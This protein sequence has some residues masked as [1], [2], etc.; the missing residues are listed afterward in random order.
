MI[1]IK[2]GS[3]ENWDT[4]NPILEAGQPGYDKNTHKLKIGDGITKWSEL[5]AIGESPT[6]RSLDASIKDFVV[7]S[8]VTDIW[9]YQ[10]WYSGIARCSC[11]LPVNT[12]ITT[13]TTASSI[14]QAD[15]IIAGINYPINFET[16]PS[17]LATLQSNVGFAWLVNKNKNTTATSGDYAIISID[18]QIQP[19]EYAISIQVEGTWKV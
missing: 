13:N 16:P 17:E 8:G 14:F 2:R 5:P 18:K 15:S 19:A 7:E 3:T 4:I 6:A 9:T 11:R 10:K 1:K 12:S